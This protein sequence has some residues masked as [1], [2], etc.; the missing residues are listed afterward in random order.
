MV[1]PA[2]L[3]LL[4]AALLCSIWRASGG[5]VNGGVLRHHRRSLLFLASLARMRRGLTWRMCAGVVR[6][7]ASLPSQNFPRSSSWVANGCEK[8]PSARQAAAQRRSGGDGRRRGI[9]GGGVSISPRQRDRPVARAE[10]RRPP[11]SRLKEEGK[12][13]VAPTAP[14]AEN[15]QATLF[16]PALRHRHHQPSRR[17][18]LCSTTTLR[19]CASR[20]PDPLQYLDIQ[21]RPPSPAVHRIPAKRT[22]LLLAPSTD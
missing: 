22:L 17:I 16:A 8:R 14:L 9:G 13:R 15:I 12:V 18:S 2:R 19:P 11:T 1:R 3:L 4:Y 21:Q 6:A 20:A 7:V 5:I 10:Q